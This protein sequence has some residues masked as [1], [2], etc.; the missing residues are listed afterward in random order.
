MTLSPVIYG[1]WADGVLGRP[2]SPP[3]GNPE[4][5]ERKISP[6]FFCQV[7]CPPWGHGRPRVRVMEVRAQMIVLQSFEGLPEVFDPGRPHK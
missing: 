1:V 3:C 6:K 7:F 4:G 2:L 5:T